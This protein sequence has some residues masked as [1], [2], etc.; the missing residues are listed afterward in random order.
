MGAVMELHLILYFLGFT[1]MVGTLPYV[2][3]EQDRVAEFI[4]LHG[5]VLMIIGIIVNHFDA[6]MEFIGGIFL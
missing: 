1:I 2:A 3:F 4:F 5:V 6:I